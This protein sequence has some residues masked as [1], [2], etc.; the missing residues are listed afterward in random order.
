MEVIGE[1]LVLVLLPRLPAVLHLHP[2]LE[3]GLWHGFF[4]IIVLRPL[5]F[6]LKISPVKTWTFDWN[7]LGYVPR[8]LSMLEVP[9]MQEE[10]KNMINSMPSD[11]APGPNGFTGT[12]SKHARK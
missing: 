8:G 7:A 3:G 6:C 5:L 4:L 2:K 11:K 1:L 10:V 12:F 9:F